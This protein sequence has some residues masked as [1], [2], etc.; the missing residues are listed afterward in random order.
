[1]KKN[2][3]SKSV[4]TIICLLGLAA[5]A[6]DPRVAPQLADEVVRVVV[7]PLQFDRSRTRLEA[8]GTSRALRS[9]ELHP[10]TS[11]E[12]VTVYFQPGQYVRQDQV[13]VELD[14]REE[15]LAVSLAEVQLQ[16]AERLYDRYQR[17]GT[18]GAVLPTTI[19][20]ARTALESARIE[21]ERAKV[22][23]DYRTIEAPFDGYVGITEVDP[24]DRINPDT[25]ITSL[26]DR[27]SLLVSFEVPE[28]LIGDLEVGSE[29]TVA[30]WNDSRA[31]A[32][33]RIVDIG[34]RIDP[35]SRTFVA[36]ASVNNQADGLRPGMSFRVSMS[37]EGT[38]YPVIA[39]TALQWGAEGA[40]VWSVVDG[41]AKRVSVNIVQRQQGQVLV[42]ANLSEGDLVVV[43]GVQRMRDGIDVIF[44][45]PNGVDL[46]SSGVPSGASD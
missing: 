40:Y 17:T 46:D 5:C 42:E 28:A 2:L 31:T 34:S 9:A 10:A 27:S 13:L 8:V 36:R 35:G 33:G 19:D 11:G 14:S 26:D 22:A 45:T 30:A 21:L 16:D 43:E 32:T 7:E 41:K 38:P 37:L 23:L 18:S 29:V 12:V 6:E 1:M 25:L 20:A 44:D 24:G 15:R 39:E 4:L 3:L